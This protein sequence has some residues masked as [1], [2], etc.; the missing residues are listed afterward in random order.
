MEHLLRFYF[1][2]RFFFFFLVPY[3][4]FSPMEKQ[5]NFEQEK[6]CWWQSKVIGTFPP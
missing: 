5:V 3:T 1:F 2:I 4:W 6:G